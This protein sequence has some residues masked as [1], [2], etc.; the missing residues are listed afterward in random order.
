MRKIIWLGA[1][2][3]IFLRWFLMPTDIPFLQ[4]VLHYALLWG[5]VMIGVLEDMQRKSII[6]DMLYELWRRDVTYL[7]RA[8]PY[9][10]QCSKKYKGIWR[11]FVPQ[12]HCMSVLF[13]YCPLYRNEANIERIFPLPESKPK[14]E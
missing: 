4:W 7:G 14:K 2:W 1:I 12:N 8:C 3:L 10:R 5:I 11:T 6:T 9:K 13:E